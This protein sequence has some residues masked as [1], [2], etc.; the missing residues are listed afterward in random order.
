MSQIK[1]TTGE[2][3]NM[4]ESLSQMAPMQMPVK[5]SYWVARVLAKLQPAY[6]ASEKARV[7]L[8]EEFG[9]KTGPKV[10]TDSPDSENWPVFEERYTELMAI[11]VDVDAPQI[12][13]SQFGDISLKPAFLM[14]LSK[15]VTE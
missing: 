15:L 7:K 8:V 10:S 9:V 14:S 6:E 5:A 4:M 11:E 3:R 12:A 13:L 2:M 1:V